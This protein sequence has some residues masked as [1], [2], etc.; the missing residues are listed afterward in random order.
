MR[1]LFATSEVYPLVKSGGLADVSRA[2]PIALRRQGVDVRIV[3]PGYDAAM[4][5]LENPRI[6]ARLSSD[7]GVEDARLIGGILPGCDVPVWLIDAP[8][9][10]S[11]RGGLYQDETGRD[12][13][14]NARRFS[15][16]SRVAAAIA[17]GQTS[18]WKADIVHANDW[19]TGLTPFYLSQYGQP[20]PSTIFTIHNLAFQGNFARHELAQAAIAEQFFVP[21]GLEF[22]GHLS[23]MKAAL[24]YSDKLTTVSPRYAQEVLTEDFG[25]KFEGLLR[26]RSKDFCG[27]LNGI[28]DDVWD[29]A[30]DPILAQRYSFSDISGKRI[31]KAELQRAL[32]LE[33]SGQIPLLGF[34]SR[35]TW[36][37]MADVLLDAVPDIMGNGAQLVIVGEGDMTLQSALAGLQ[38]RYPGQFVLRPYCEALTHRLVA[39]SDILLAPA[40]FEPCGLTQMYALR[41]GALPVVRRTGGLADTVVDAQAPNIANAS[42]TGFVFDRADREAFLS[43]I[44]RA[45]TLFHEPLAWRRLQLAG[46][47]RDFGWNVS[48][49]Q[50]VSLYS[51]LSGLSKPI[52]EPHTPNQQVWQREIRSAQGWA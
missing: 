26:S 2:L 6:E 31:C 7:L 46:M 51:E 23:F 40:R 5:R 42:A 44:M 3:L 1:V 37:K 25:F 11:R 34:C 48:A 30:K 52:A 32:G 8:S 13:T 16:L 19:H 24:R 20:R 14:D 15:V 29:P 10:Y 18:S 17:M 35:I 27:I 47:K 49:A 43:A 22:Y 33:V 38:Q 39:A 28:E 45:L 9:L 36:Q 50:Y 41:Y 12:W 21:E 4:A